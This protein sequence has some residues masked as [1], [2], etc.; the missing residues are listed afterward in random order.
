M[1]RRTRTLTCT[2]HTRPSGAHFPFTSRTAVAGACMCRVGQGR[3]IPRPVAMHAPTGGKLQGR[4]SMRHHNSERKHMGC[5]RVCGCRNAVTT[6]TVVVN[7]QRGTLQV[8]K[9]A[10]QLSY[11]KSVDSNWMSRCH[12]VFKC[13]VEFGKWPSRHFKCPNFVCFLL[14]CN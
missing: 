10:A 11:S 14:V 2:W 8:V 12:V 13:W 1:W 5:I 9:T 6:S 3:G 4:W 7:M